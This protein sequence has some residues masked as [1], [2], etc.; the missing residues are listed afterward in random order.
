LQV[1]DNR[2]KEVSSTGYQPSQQKDLIETLIENK[3]LES[4]DQR[5][6]E[7]LITRQELLDEF[8]TFYVGGT[9]TTGHLIAY[10]LYILAK[11]SFNL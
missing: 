7:D 11:V 1:I 3:T 2:I 5:S 8:A 4:N 10:V 9:D 6:S